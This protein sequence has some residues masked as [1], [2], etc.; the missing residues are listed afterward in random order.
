MTASVQIHLG[1]L[2]ANCRILQQRVT[3]LGM[4]WQPQ[5]LRNTPD[6]VVQQL[7]LAGVRGVCSDDY[8]L[9]QR[10]GSGRFS[11][12]WLLDRVV[13]RNEIEALLNRSDT[14]NIVLTIDHFVHAERVAEVSA[15]IGLTQDVLIEIE[16]GRGL[17]AVRPGREVAMLA[18]AVTTLPGVRFTGIVA[19]CPRG[20]TTEE[21]LFHDVISGLA[22]TLAMLRKSR[23]SCDVV[24]LQGIP[25]EILR[26]NSHPFTHVMDH[27]GLFGSPCDSDS[28]DP[29]LLPALTAT[30]QVVSRPSLSVAV[31]NIGSDVLGV[32]GRNPRVTGLGDTEIIAMGETRL[33][34]RLIGEARDIAIGDNVTLEIPA[35]SAALR[36]ADI[37]ETQR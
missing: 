12:T 17:G 36:H 13:A 10:V 8:E 33:S 34:L 21:S 7:S 2:A 23:L 1:H 5:L 15:R 14:R 20:T 19:R 3:G 9:L 22:Y 37:F 26:Q 32:A 18:E 35:T 25:L 24:S 28:P 29:S 27:D 6:A 16:A 4:T 30:A 11:S 31:I